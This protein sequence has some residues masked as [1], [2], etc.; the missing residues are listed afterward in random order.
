LTD[1]ADH[2]HD[3]TGSGPASLPSRRTPRF[4]VPRVLRADRAPP[5]AGAPGSRGRSSGARP[6]LVV[7][8]RH[9]PRRAGPPATTH[10]SRRRTAMTVDR[11]LLALLEAKPGKGPE[12]AAF[13]EQGRALAAEEA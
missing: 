2:A 10:P 9:T 11:G 5:G 12:L 8:G 1:P 13:L 4:P 7:G 6:S 3:A